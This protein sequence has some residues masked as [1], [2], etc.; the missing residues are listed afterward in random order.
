MVA[1]CALAGC[2]DTAA[3]RG[4][5]VLFASGADLQSPNPLF[6]VHPLARQ[7]Q[8]YVLLTTLVQYDSAMQVVPY[9]ARRWAWS[10]DGRRLT[11]TLTPDLRWHDGVPTTAHDAAW[12][13]TTAQDLGVGYPRLTDLAG[14]TATAPDDSTLVL[15]FASAPGRVPDVL[16]DLAILPQ[17]LLDTVPRARL[18]QAAWNQSPV[19]NGPFRFVAH[20][21]NRR[22]VFA[23]NPDFPSRLG[24][25]PALERL[26]IAVVDEPM[27]KLAALAAGELDFAGIQPA[28]ARFVAA[29]PALRTV[30]YPLL[31]SVG[32]V[33]NARHAPFDRLAARA[34]VAGAIDRQAIVDGFTY[35]FGTPGDQPVLPEVPLPALPP[36]P[37]PAMPAEPPPSFELLTV[38][39]GEAAME[40]MLQ[41]Q[42]AR[43]GMTVRIRQLE[44]SAFL[45][46]V[47]G[48]APD[49]D[50]A[51]L[52]TPG[53]LGLGYLAPLA[54]LSGL[55]APAGT[56]AVLRFIA[57]SV[58][59]TMIYHARGLQGMNRRVQG[60][61]FGLRGELATVSRW[62]VAP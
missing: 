15:S 18:R 47:Y 49:F 37:R 2:G 54:E 25:P 21:P 39:S 9:L 41:A 10:A 5:T 28:H 51:V 4:N 12:T 55:R 27:T 43:H 40:Q 20:E 3:R 62:H 1:A 57:D 14:L 52:G 60:V 34:A 56:A 33:F 11:M 8:R 13:L 31:F 38:G 59:V 19:G 45:A 29:R 32:I 6:T 35:G 36:R 7:V 48:P 53:D 17:H 26:V 30:D 22:W 16:T 50:A 24:G 58:P 42:L 61:A 23:R 46:R 44:L